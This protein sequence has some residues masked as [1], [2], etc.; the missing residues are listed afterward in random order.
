MAK[1]RNVFDFDTLTASEDGHEI[2]ASC[3]IKPDAAY[4]KGHFDNLPVMPA[5]AQLL[6]LE[7]LL[8]NCNWGQRIASVQSCKFFSLIHPEQRIY[9][10]LTMSTTKKIKFKIENDNRIFTQGLLQLAGNHDSQ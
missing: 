9:I 10:Q 4:F 7:A 3:M 6:M 1:N 8:K 5:V 2:T